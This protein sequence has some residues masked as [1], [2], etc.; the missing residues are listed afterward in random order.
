MVVL[1]GGEFDGPL[2]SGTALPG[3]GGDLC[4]FRPDGVLSA[5]ARNLLQDKLWSPLR[6]PASV[7]S[8][9]Q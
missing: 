5:D 9:C 3:N 2:V 7:S 1:D 4:L 8:L 6:R